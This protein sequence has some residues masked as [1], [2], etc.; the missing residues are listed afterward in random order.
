M[1]YIIVKNLK[2]PQDICGKG[3]IVAY[4]AQLYLSAYSSYIVMHACIEIYEY[5]TVTKCHT[6]NKLRTKSM[7]C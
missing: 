1:K 7:Y 5:Q 2:F 6:I 4:V 3:L